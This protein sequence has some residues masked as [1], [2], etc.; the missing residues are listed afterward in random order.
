M[1]KFKTDKNGWIYIP[2]AVGTTMNKQP[3]DSE[4]AAGWTN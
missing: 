4:A 3:Q 1:N 2:V